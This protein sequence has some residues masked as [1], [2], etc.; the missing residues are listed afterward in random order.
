MYLGLEGSQRVDTHGMSSIK[1]RKLRER[2][3]MEQIRKVQ[4]HVFYF[5]VF[6]VIQCSVDNY[7]ST[8]HSKYSKVLLTSSP[9]FSYSTFV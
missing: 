5:D 3:A 6:C 8:H 4:C 1:V 7:L 2:H 9:P